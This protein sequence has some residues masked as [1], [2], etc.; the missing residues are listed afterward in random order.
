M[1]R[2]T[3]EIR[4][5]SPRKM[6]VPVL[7][8]QEDKEGIIAVASGLWV[9]RS[10][11]LWTVVKFRSF[12]AQKELLRIVRKN[13]LQ[14]VR[15]CAGIPMN[16]RWFCWHG[17]AGRRIIVTRIIV[18]RI[19]VARII[20]AGPRRERRETKGKNWGDAIS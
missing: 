8:A 9:G 1:I 13:L 10:D 12:S 19:I 16:L 15:T 6:W 2:S 18:T 11:F 3:D 14:F 7:G 20:V 4:G 5:A 17:L